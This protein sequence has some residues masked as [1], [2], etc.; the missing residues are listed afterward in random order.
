MTPEDLQKLLANAESEHLEFKE[1]Y[2]LSGVG[3][4]RQKDELAKDILALANSVSKEPAYLIIG[5]SDMLSPDGTR[6]GKG[7]A[8]NSYDL[9]LFLSITNARCSPPIRN[10]EY[11]EIELDNIRYGVLK[12]VNSGTKPHHCI[13]DLIVS[14]AR[15]SQNTVFIRRGDQIG[16]AAPSEIKMM[17]LD[18]PSVAPSHE[19][20]PKSTVSTEECHAI[21][22]LTPLDFGHTL[23][24]HAT[25]HAV[26]IRADSKKEK[27]L[28]SLVK[29]ILANLQC[30]D[31][32]DIHDF[33][34][35]L[36]SLE[37]PLRDLREMGGEL[38]CVMTPE[39]MKTQDS[40]IDITVAHYFFHPQRLF[41]PTCKP[42]ARFYS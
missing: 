6:I 3:Q 8:K 9:S 25:T 28:R 37:D 18:A 20:K 36:D 31:N 24:A 39:K 10:A 41:S 40:P 22:I 1:E 29:N 19:S 5:A 30:I 14:K 23:G 34:D 13:R 35:F 2:V 42:T 21:R 32:G 27:R 33:M 38:F 12:L 11:S 7:I 16:A 4:D 15:W 17:E 26:L